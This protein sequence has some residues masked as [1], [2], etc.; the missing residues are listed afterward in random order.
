MSDEIGDGDEAPASARSRSRT[1]SGGGGESEWCEWGRV[2]IG[3][4]L[5]FGEV[6]L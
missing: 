3:W 1:G 6:A 5:G 2:G 4:G